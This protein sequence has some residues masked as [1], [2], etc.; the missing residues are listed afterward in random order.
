[1]VGKFCTIS[2]TCGRWS[3]SSSCHTWAIF[4]SFA[5]LSCNSLVIVVVVAVLTRILW[6]RSYFTERPALGMIV[7]IACIQ[8]GDVVVRLDDGRWIKIRSGQ[9]DSTWKCPKVN[10]GRD[11]GKFFPTPQDTILHGIYCNKRTHPWL[12]PSHERSS[13]SLLISLNDTTRRSGSLVTVG[14]IWVVDNFLVRV[15]EQLEGCLGFYSTIWCRLR[16]ENSFTVAYWHDYA[17]HGHGRRS[18]VRSA[19]GN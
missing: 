13:S 14:A 2:L 6:L 3:H 17:K 11:R 4:V 9:L 7:I 5:S 18:S 1:M 8:L 16:F 19:V 15:I 10:W 12:L